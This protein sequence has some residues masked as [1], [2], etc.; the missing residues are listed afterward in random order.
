MFRLTSNASARVIITM[1]FRNK[2][3]CLGKAVVTAFIFIYI[4]WPGDTFGQIKIGE[5]KNSDRAEGCSCSFQVPSE[6]RKRNSTKFIFVSELGSDVGWMNLNGRDIRLKLI[7]STQNA[8]GRIRVG[9]RFYEEYSG[10]GFSVRIDYTVTRVCPPRDEGCEWTKYN[11]TITASKG[12]S[13]QSIK[14]AGECGC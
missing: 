14:G 8:R 12:S 11:V 13:S 2:I 3:Q 5:L 1:L 7:R 9:D 4:C 10:S 6:A